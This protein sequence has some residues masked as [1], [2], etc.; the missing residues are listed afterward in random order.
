MQRG[1]QSPAFVRRLVGVQARGDDQVDPIEPT[2]HEIVGLQPDRGQMVPAP[3]IEHPLRSPCVQD[4]DPRR[5]GQVMQSR[6]SLM[7]GDA[8]AGQHDEGRGGAHGLDRFLG[9]LRPRVL[10]SGGSGDRAIDQLTWVQVETK[11][12]FP[13]GRQCG[14]GRQQRLGCVDLDDEARPSVEAGQPEVAVP[15]VRR[16]THPVDSL[17]GHREQGGHGGGHQ[18]HL[19]RTERCPVCGVDAR[20]HGHPSPQFRRRDDGHE[21]ISTAAQ[22]RVKSLRTP[23]L[24]PTE[25][26]ASRRRPRGPRPGRDDPTWRPVRSRRPCRRR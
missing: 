6:D 3:P 12:H 10:G 4:A 22:R 8:G 5:H 25:H 9:R 20:Q 19:E 13:G 7:P 18:Y 26:P 23:R 1:G 16:R 24:W 15:S 11:L 21:V 2:Q 14:G 17:V